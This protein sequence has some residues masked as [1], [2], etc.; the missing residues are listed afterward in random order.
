VLSVVHVGLVPGY[1]LLLPGRTGLLMAVVAA[2]TAVACAFIAYRWRQLVSQRDE[3]SARGARTH[4]DLVRLQEL[5]YA[6]PVGLTVSDEH[7]R[8]VQV[9]REIGQMVGL[10]EAEL[11]GS[12]AAI[13]THPGD[14]EFI[15]RSGETILASPEGIAKIETRYVHT[16]GSVLW[17]WLTLTHVA[18]PEGQVWTLAHVQDITQRK[19]SEE[20]LRLSHQVIQAARV[21]AHAV[22][23]GDDPRQLIVEQ[24]R[25]IAGAASVQFVEQLDA[26][27]LVVT[28]SSGEPGLTGTQIG[29][30]D[31]S[32][33][34]QVW[35]TGQPVF[36]DTTPERADPHQR[37]L[38]NAEACSTIW[39]PV[40]VDGVVVAIVVIVWPQR[41]DDVTDLQRTALDTIVAETSLALM[42]ERL[43]HSLEEWSVTDPLT[44]LLNRRGWERQIEALDAERREVQWPTVIAILD[45]DHFKAFNDTHG[46]PAGD[47]ALR[48]FGAAVK[49]VLRDKDLVA[50]WGGEEFAIALPNCPPAAAQPALQRLAGCVAPGLT[51]SIGFTL[52][53]P[54]G[55]VNEAIRRADQSLYA[56]KD[57]GRDQIRTDS[58]PVPELSH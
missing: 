38:E 47:T 55:D 12:S 32:P 44:G 31:T 10:S 21:I 29:L 23:R 14:L 24:A 52:M 50:R 43:R 36:M 28:T 9:N 39:A 25:E 49:A 2:L 33:C 37:Q 1:V 26:E 20:Q 8:L 22:Q 48:S 5:V 53:G 11:L 51:C 57:S 27:H 56:A 16:D 17:V 35:A 46:H 7:G 45:F 40:L 42:S 3:L 54:E 34:G 19:E 18:G 4:A 30:D 13:F 15:S 41:V 6:S 58:T